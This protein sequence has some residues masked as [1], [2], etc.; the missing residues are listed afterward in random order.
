MTSFFHSLSNWFSPNQSLSNARSKGNPTQ[1]NPTKK[2]REDIQ[3]VDVKVVKHTHVVTSQMTD[4][5]MPIDSGVSG[6]YSTHMTFAK[7]VEGTV[8]SN[9]IASENSDAHGQ[10]IYPN[11]MTSNTTGPRQSPG[12]YQSAVVSTPRLQ[13]KTN[14]FSSPETFNCPTS[15]RECDPHVQQK[16]TRRREKEPM[17]FNG[18][19]DWK[20]YLGHFN[21]VAE[22]NGWTYSELGLQLAISLTDDAR[23]V[24]G[25][26]TGPEQHDFDTLKDALTR[27]FSPEGRESQY[28]LQLMSLTCRPDESVTSYGQTVRRLA[29]RAYPGQTVDEQ[30]LVDLYI[31]GLPN[32]DMKRHVYLAKPV[33]LA[34]AVNYAVTFEAFDSPL[35]ESNKIHKPKASVNAIK[36]NQTPETPDVSKLTNVFEK[37]T[38]SVSKLT[39][40]VEKLMLRNKSKGCAHSKD[41]IEC[42]KCHDKGHYAKECPLINSHAKSHQR[43]NNAQNGG[44]SRAHLN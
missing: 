14:Q 16:V 32:K 30:I 38:D 5:E 37:M 33:T 20:D 11:T 22:W 40:N 8:D 4:D 23:E 26:L 39:E 24:L 29:N 35:A 18:K 1:N 13:P 21:A 25:S 17:K 12:F 36:A 43:G 10:G 34:Q 7:T 2:P 15:L 27:R 19:T 28:S 41:N 42:Y 6:D 44:S 9:D 3:N 31:K